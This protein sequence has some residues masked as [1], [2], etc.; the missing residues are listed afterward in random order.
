MWTVI[1]PANDELDKSE[2]EGVHAFLI[3]SHEDSTMVI[4]LILLMP[5]LNVILSRVLLLL[6]CIT[7]RFS[8]QAKKLTKWIKVVLVHKE[9]LCLLVT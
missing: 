5:N 6:I 1:G 9:R 2:T 8:K 3:L 7:F 4:S